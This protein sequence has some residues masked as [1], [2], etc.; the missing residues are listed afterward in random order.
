MNIMIGER[1]CQT[2]RAKMAETKT[3]EIVVNGKPQRVPEGLDVTGLLR[4]L[5]IDASRVAVAGVPAVVFG[6]GDIAQAHT[7]D[8]WVALDEVARAS[9]IL[10]RLARAG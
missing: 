5:A 1:R 10:Y 4:F 3:I 9:E 8:E 2:P 6:P 7:R